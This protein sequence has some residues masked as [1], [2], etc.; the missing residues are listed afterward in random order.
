MRLHL[1]GERD[2]YVAGDW[3]CDKGVT[4]PAGDKITINVGTTDV[5]CT[6]TSSRKGELVVKKVTDPKAATQD[7]Q[8]RPRGWNND[9]SFELTDGQEKSAS[10]KIAPG[11]YSVA[12]TVPSG[13]TLDGHHM[14]RRRS[15]PGDGDA[16]YVHV[17]AGTKV[18]CE[19]TNTKETAWLRLQKEV[20]GGSAKPADWLLGRCGYAVR[21]Q[22][23]RQEA[24]EHH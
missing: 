6:I 2:N 3:S 19:F 18:T 7:V 9:G 5:S 4:P 17:P 12:E 21:R 23:H 22:G 24:G 14:R 20:E 1:A 11:T 8:L 10:G 13:W 15:R 16:V